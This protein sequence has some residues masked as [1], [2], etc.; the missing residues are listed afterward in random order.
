[1]EGGT[2]FP[3]G[4]LRDC[5]FNSSFTWVFNIS[6]ILITIP[7]LNQCLV[8][9]L[10]EYKP[11]MRKKIAI[12]YLLVVLASVCMVAMIGAGE[13]ELRSHGGDINGNSTR[14][15]S[16]CLFSDLDESDYIPL[17]V[18]S[19]VIVVPHF[20]VS[21]AEVFINVSCKLQNCKMCIIMVHKG[22]EKGEKGWSELQLKVDFCGLETK[23]LHKFMCSIDILY[24]I[25]GIH[26]S[27]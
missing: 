24:N 27:L 19:W 14:L 13:R 25:P 17:P 8:P 26:P 2:F 20:L 5:S 23:F 6:V 22:K 16:L 11:N 12:G 21:V 15:L 3:N 18:R 1:M 7:V 10:R 9:F 4:L